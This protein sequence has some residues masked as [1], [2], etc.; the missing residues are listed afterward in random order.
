MEEL[1]EAVPRMVFTIQYFGT[2]DQLLYTERVDADELIDVIDRARD[3]LREAKLAVDWP[4]VQPQVFGYVILNSIGRA[5]GRGY[6][7]GRQTA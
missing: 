2:H 6:T 3:V 1:P 5:V 7:R 4:R